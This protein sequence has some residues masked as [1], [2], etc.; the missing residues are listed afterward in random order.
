MANPIPLIPIDASKNVRY[1]SLRTGRMETWEATSKDGKWAFHRLEMSG[2]PWEVTHSDFP[3]WS[4]LAGSLRKAR[5]YAPGQLALDLD[6]IARGAVMTLQLPDPFASVEIGAYME[7]GRRYLS[8]R[9]MD[10]GTLHRNAYAMAWFEVKE[11]EAFRGDRLSL[12]AM[13]RLTEYGP[14]G[15]LHRRR[16]RGPVPPGPPRH[17]PLRILRGLEGVPRPEGRPG[18]PRPP[19]RRGG[20]HQGRRVASPPRGTSGGPRRRPRR[21]P[22]HRSPGS[23]RDHDHQPRGPPTPGGLRPR[24]PRWGTRRSLTRSGDLVPDGSILD[25]HGLGSLSS[26][27]AR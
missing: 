27:I 7:H 21:V 13:R 16:P 26:S 8:W 22:T 17:R 4:M 11:W 15:V 19:G 1:Q 9:L 18:R 24:P 20:G 3:G 2:T 10:P 12:S 23:V 6:V 5:L 14:R 25:R